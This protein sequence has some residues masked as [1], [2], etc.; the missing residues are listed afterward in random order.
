MMI[1]VADDVSAD[2]DL[3]SIADEMIAMRSLGSPLGRIAKRFKTTIAAVLEAQTIANA[4]RAARESAERE[5]RRLARSI[6]AESPERARIDV[7]VEDGF[8]WLRRRGWTIA[9]IAHDGETTR[10]AV[11]RGLAN[12]Q[13]R[14]LER[15]RLGPIKSPAIKLRPIFPPLGFGPSAP[16]PHRVDIANGSTDCCMCCHRSGIDYQVWMQKDLRDPKPDEKPKPVPLARF[17]RQ[18]RRRLEYAVGEAKHAK[19]ALHR[20]DSRLNAAARDRS[21]TRRT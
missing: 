19:K 1:A 21:A 5:A 15:R 20:L 13:S 8:L 18:E 16:C 14:E 9:E 6:K 2:I 4:N 11:H 12:A 10:H 3:S 17:T 7:G